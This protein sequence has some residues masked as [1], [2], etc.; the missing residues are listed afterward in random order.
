MHDTA[1]LDDKVNTKSGEK[2]EKRFLQAIPHPGGGGGAHK[3]SLGRGVP[4]RHD[5]SYRIK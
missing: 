1:R 3:G 2:G 5:F 4:P